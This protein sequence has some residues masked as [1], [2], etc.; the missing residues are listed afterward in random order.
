MAA[1]WASACDEVL[2]HLD[3]DFGQGVSSAEAER[4]LDACGPNRIRRQESTPWWMI[5]LRQFRSAV[6]LILA[7]AAVVSFAFGRAPE[8]VAILVVVLINAAIGFFT[9]L[10]AVRSM[11]ALERMGRVE[12][13]VRRDGDEQ[14]VPSERVVPGDIV[15]LE[16]GDIVPADLRILQ[17]AK[18]EVDES[19]LTG[20]SESV[21]KT[22]EPVENDAPLAD[23]ASMLYKGTS[24]VRGM[25]RMAR[26][27]A[28][29]N[30]LAA[31]ETLGGAT[32][33]CVDKTGT[34]TENRMTVTRLVLSDGTVEV[35][36]RGYELEGDF[37]RDGETV[38]PASFP[39]LRDALRA[40]ALC[41]NAEVD[42]DDEEAEPVDVG[43][44][45]AECR[46][47]PGDG[48]R[49]SVRGGDAA[50][51]AFR[52]GL[53]DG[54]SG[55]YCF[56]PRR[57]VRAATVG[58]SGRPGLIHSWNSVSGREDPGRRQRARPNRR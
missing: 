34:L 51:G 27:H 44:C 28:L 56:S 16:E 15:V 31:V 14:A 11:E 36:G 5:L 52:P 48:L 38:D 33:I 2:E 24:L 17:A 46:A 35:T 22:E 1:P 54:C 49:G 6:I 39:L 9:E 47:H 43:G 4:R 40:G 30:R 57:P 20:E 50:H 3:V 7:A 42:T 10:R 53:A 18:L 32:V 19:A 25:R 37:L 41:V 23:R 55:G 29:V 26:R 45:R 13:R 58:A 21:V 8:G 12:T